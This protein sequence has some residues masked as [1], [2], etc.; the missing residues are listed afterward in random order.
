MPFEFIIPTDAD[1]IQLHLAEGESAIF[2]G[3]N[4]AG[5][6]RL[7]VHI[8]QTAG[9]KAHRISAHRALILKPDV[10]K[11]SEEKALRGLRLGNVNEDA[12]LFHRDLHRWHRG[13]AT[14]LLND[15]DHLVQ[16]LFAEQ[17]ITSLETH[18]LARA[19]TLIEA[20]QTKFER[21]Q[22]IWD[23]LLPH[24]ALA[25]TGDDIK[26][27]IPQNE[28]KYSASEMSDGER[29]IFYLIGQTL[30]A[31]T[32]SLLVIDEPELHIHRSILS[33]LWDLLENERPDCSFVFITHDLHF[34]ASRVGQKYFVKNYLPD[35]KWTIQPVPQDTGFPE[36]ITTLLLG[37]RRPILFVEGEVSSL[38]KAVYRCVYPEWTVIPRGSC[39]DVIH[40]VSTLRNNSHLAHV[41]C[42]GIV[43]ADGYSSEEAQEFARP[44]ISVLPVAEL[45]NIFLLPNVSR[46]IASAAHFDSIQ[47]TERLDAL[48]NDIFTFAQTAGVLDS[49]SKRHCLRSIDRILKKIDLSNQPTI[50][51]MDRQLRALIQGL[52]PSAIAAEYSTKVE[53]AIQARDLNALLSLLDNKG[54]FAKAGLRLRENSR[55]AFESWLVRL[56]LNDSAPALLAQLRQVLPS[57]QLPEAAAH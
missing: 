55:Q 42:A 46:E 29:A 51:Q 10:P 18:K 39:K 2:V 28:V 43:D 27:F 45:E 35:P 36:D 22:S 6:T 12:K 13:P 47:A 50:D 49:A 20:K 26:T 16:A 11:I 32:N 21:L 17:S 41:H 40:A 19:R 25:I 48:A 5:K 53:S 57:L 9:E 30:V 31:K 7:A 8:E 1:P 44:G 54:M 3:A 4:G 38:D 14:G 52:E 34:G 37:S 15:F 23:R 33:K 24:R 56:L